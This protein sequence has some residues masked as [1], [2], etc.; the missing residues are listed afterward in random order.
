MAS[1]ISIV[2]PA[3]EAVLKISKPSLIGKRVA[4]PAC[5]KP[6]LIQAPAAADA[7]I[8]AS[9]PAR[10]KEAAA[11]K[12]PPGTSSADPDTILLAEDDDLVG[13]PLPTPVAKPTKND[14]PSKKKPRS[15]A[16]WK[17]MS[18]TETAEFEAMLEDTEAEDDPATVE[19]SFVDE[20]GHSGGTARGGKR[21]RSG[22][23]EFDAML[24]DTDTEQ[25][26]L[27]AELP[28]A[29]KTERK[30][31]TKSRAASASDPDK[32]EMAAEDSADDDYGSEPALPPRTSSMV[33]H[34]RSASNSAQKLPLIIGAF[35][36]GSLL[37]GLLLYSVS[38]RVLR[39][40]WPSRVP[41]THRSLRKKK[42]KTPHNLQ[43][44]VRR[45]NLSR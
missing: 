17:S 21:G 19:L 45:R 41:P 15:S 39:L 40:P 33:A 29:A 35:V 20:D 37:M 31:K 24:V 18:E 5:K 27:T 43:R 22:S 7:Q 11:L 25:D 2:C 9:K 13:R 23:G 6:V 14:A 1:S 4:C 30:R 12:K 36:G 8:T 3:C 42:R 26:E 38:G 32:F 16:V 10:P 44:K 28:T 34:R